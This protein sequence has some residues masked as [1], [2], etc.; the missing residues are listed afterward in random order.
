MPPIEIKV[1]D[2]SSNDGSRDMQWFKQYSQ[3][4]GGFFTPAIKVGESGKTYY[5]WGKDK[6]D[7][8][9]SDKALSATDKLKADI[10]MEIQDILSKIDID[11]V[12]YNKDLY[13]PAESVQARTTDMY[14]PFDGYTR[15]CIRG[16]G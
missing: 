14:T 12:M 2:V 5:L 16:D 1:V 3:K 11:P 15:N 4:I 6:E 10:I 7:E 9:I 13:N 8:Q